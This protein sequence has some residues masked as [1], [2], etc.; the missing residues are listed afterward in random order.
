MPAVTSCIQFLYP[1]VSSFVPVVSSFVSSFQFETGN[2]TGYMGKCKLQAV[3]QKIF[4][5]EIIILS[6]INTFCLFRA[7][8][9]VPELRRR[10]VC[11]HFKLDFSQDFDKGSY[12]LKFRSNL[13]SWSY[14]FRKYLQK[15]SACG[16]KF[17]LIFFVWDAILPCIRVQNHA[18]QDQKFSPAA[19]NG[20]LFRIQVTIFWN[21]Q[22]KGSYCLKFSSK[23]WIWWYYRGGASYFYLSGSVSEVWTLAAQRPIFSIYLDSCKKT[24]WIWDIFDCILSLPIPFTGFQ[25]TNLY[26]WFQYFH[27]Q[28]K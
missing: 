14:C 3:D 23:C 18:K 6:Y 22:P 24:Q 20:P 12:C 8:G 1:V 21:F 4:L 25:F 27:H 28:M 5:S 26:L 11:A 17:P 16:A 2:K 9:K 15:F 13:S 7:L 10:S 19:Q